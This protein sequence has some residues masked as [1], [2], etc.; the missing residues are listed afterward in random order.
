MQEKNSE[1]LNPL[2]LHDMPDDLADALHT[3]DN[4][5]TLWDRLTDLGR[6]EFICWVISA[7]RPETRTRRIHRV[8]E[9]LQEGKRRPC[10]WPGCPHR[11]PGAQKWF[12]QKKH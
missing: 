9:E 10:Y 11:R 8:L 5:N 2:G 3:L 7:K 12:T 4:G 6:N 1:K